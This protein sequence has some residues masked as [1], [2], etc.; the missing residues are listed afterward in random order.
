MIGLY[1]SHQRLINFSVKM[2]YYDNFFV[3]EFLLD[4]I[5]LCRQTCH[6]SIGLNGQ[7]RL[8]PSILLCG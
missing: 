1:L 7:R 3:G 6:Q 5:M 8:V 4:K 2:V